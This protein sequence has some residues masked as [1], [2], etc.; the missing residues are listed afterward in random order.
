MLIYNDI[1]YL[2]INY[3]NRNATLMAGLWYPYGARRNICT[4][5]VEPLVWRPPYARATVAVPLSL[6]RNK[7]TGRQ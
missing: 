6:R 4:T 2:I 7:R 5:A 3:I 1:T